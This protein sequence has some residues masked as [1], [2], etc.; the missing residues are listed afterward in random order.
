[1]HLYSIGNITTYN[2]SNSHNGIDDY[3]Q[4]FCLSIMRFDF[5]SAGDLHLVLP[6]DELMHAR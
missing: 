3:L 2:E 1:M 5:L 4:P 6:L